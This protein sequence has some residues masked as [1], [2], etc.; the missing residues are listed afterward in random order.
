MKLSIDPKLL[1]GTVTAAARSLPQRPVIPVLSGLLL[2]A[3]DDRITVSAFDYDIAHRSHAAADVAE[4]GRV[5]LPGRVLAEVAKS[6]PTGVFVEV[7]ATDTE[8]TLTCGRSEFVLPTL[9]ADDFPALPEPPEPAG[10]VDGDVF[11]TAI[12]QVVT[13]CSTDDT[14]PMLTGIRVDADGD[15]L[16]LAATDRYRIALRDLSW[17]PASA[18]SIGKL[19]PGRILHDI[20]R[21]LGHGPVTLAFN[22][23]LAAFTTDTRQSTIRLLDEEYIDYR[24]RLGIDTPI[25]ARVNAPALVDAVKRVALVAERN[26]TIRLSFTAGEVLVQA[27]GADIGRGSDVVACELDGDIEI[28]F[29]SKYLLDALNAIDGQA[30]IGMTEPHQPALITSEDGAYRNLTMAVRVA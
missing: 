14:L 25:V 10:T 29:Q 5:L 24:R 4:P 19:V 20:A 1:A 22:D 13:A 21:D 2:E 18:S 17:R 9:P 23:Q 12:H 3:A 26:T 7:T 30:D 27:G 11:V 15:T 8:A 28:A 16:T 6:L